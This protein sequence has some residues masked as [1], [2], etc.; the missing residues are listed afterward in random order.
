MNKSDARIYDIALTFLPC[1]GNINVKK[2]FSCFNNTQDIFNAKVSDLKKCPGI[3]LNTAQK[4]F[5]SL[6]TAVDLANKELEF[7]Y[8][9]DVNFTSYNDN[10][11]PYRLKE[12]VDSPFLLYYK[13]NINFNKEKIIAI[14]GTRNP[15][16]YGIKFCE[17]LIEDLSVKYP[18]CVIISGLAYGID[19]VSH[20]AALK[21][22]LETWA[23]LGNGLAT[24]YPLQ[25]KK[26]VDS[27]LANNGSILCDFSHDTKPDAM[28]FPKRNRIVAGL[29]DAVIVVES[30][31]KGGSMITATIANSYNRDVFALP[32]NID[33]VN[34]TGCN[35]LI[36]T[37]RA[38]LIESV[39][40][41]EYI[42]NWSPIN[43]KNKKEIK[44][45]DISNFNY[46]EQVIIETLE[47]EDNLEIDLLMRE[48]GLDINSLN[49][50]LLELEIK[51]II[52][53]LPG[54]TFRLNN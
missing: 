21:H 42:L 45:I 17:N 8:K 29:C 14:V 24:I 37:N 52:K 35:K 43:N 51:D 5:S 13:G 27:I 10:D 40:D 49:L 33:L 11:Y 34:S 19:I 38:N 4:I 31:I 16:N 54:K 3:G 20:K 15:S 25:H 18:D 39:D 6:Q 41:L 28:N 32:G 36:K 26:V 23:V 9:N 30:G 53:S 12:C 48:T 22:K 50:T 2:I 44:K 1:L 47:K 46:F 7:I